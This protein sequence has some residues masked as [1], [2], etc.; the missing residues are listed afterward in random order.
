MK[1]EICLIFRILSLHM[2][3]VRQREGKSFLNLSVYS[4]FIYT[5]CEKVSGY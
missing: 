2:D 1:S 5:I 4:V 3:K